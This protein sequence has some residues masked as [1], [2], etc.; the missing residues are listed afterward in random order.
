MRLVLILIA[1]SL[2]T[3]SDTPE[4]LVEQLGAAR[5]AEREAASEALRS[6]GKAAL[7]PLRAARED[8]EAEVRVRAS[9]LLDTIESDLL[10][11]PTRV[12]LD[13]HDAPLSGVIADLGRQAGLQLNLISAVPPGAA[14]PR[15][16]L[17]S[18]G[19]IT[20]WKALDR[21][22]EASELALVPSLQVQN[23]LPGGG[24]NSTPAL[25]LQDSPGGPGP[26]AE[27]GPFHLLVSKLTDTRE[28][29]FGAGGANAIGVFVNQN[30]RIVPA[31]V[32]Q[33]RGDDP[34]R[35]QLQES[36]T[37]DLQLS[38]EPRMSII[39]EGAPTLVEA[40]D[41][42]GQSLLPPEAPEGFQVHSGYNGMNSVGAS[43]V[44]FSMGLALPERP[45][46][47]IKRLKVAVPILVLSRRDDPLIVS[48]APE[49]RGKASRNSQV[50]LTVHEVGHEG[51]N[52]GFSTIEL[53]VKV[54]APG[55]DL[56]NQGLPPE[57]MA[58]RSNY[59]GG[60]SRVEIVDK[61]GRPYP[62]WFPV[63]L[64]PGS[65][66]TRLTLRLMPSADLGPPVAI[67]YYEM[68]QTSTIANFTLTDVPLF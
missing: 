45:G 21:L 24:T 36:F 7:E 30:G 17:H 40:V 41:E 35:G 19:P 51:P 59:A 23:G 61:A 1:A 64:R 8:P 27:D 2:P 48:L 43:F 53:T 68:S 25:A 33:P 10:L 26:V 4:E 14:E 52:A 22:C 31:G 3:A 46:R 18:D 32:P 16:S 37:I 66:G 47:F 63:D 50:V 62:Q 15:I 55:P 9:G 20:L 42:R 56:A 58:F 12:S 5:Y 6:L 57:M 29:S 39:T 60:Q 65:D 54:S 38:A 44:G 49:H 13:Y 28:R 67:R 11:T 34:R